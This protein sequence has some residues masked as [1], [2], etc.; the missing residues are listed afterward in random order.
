MMIGSIKSQLAHMS[1]EKQETLLKL[2]ILSVAA[3][4]CIFPFCQFL[5]FIPCH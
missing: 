3:V 2:A 1:V 4:L 5:L